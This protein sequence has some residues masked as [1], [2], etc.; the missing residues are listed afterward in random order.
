[1]EIFYR[2]RESRQQM[3]KELNFLQIRSEKGLQHIYYVA[4][5]MGHGDCIYRAVLSNNLWW[6]DIST[7]F[8]CC[9]LR[10]IGRNLHRDVRLEDR[11][12]DEYSPRFEVSFSCLIPTD[13]PEI[14]KPE[15]TRKCLCWNWKEKSYILYICIHIMACEVYEGITVGQGTLDVI[16][17]CLYLSCHDFG[18]ALSGRIEGTAKKQVGPSSTMFGNNLRKEVSSILPKQLSTE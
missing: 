7:L 8:S 9:R 13:L 3:S 6:I 11:D 10:R 17:P 4:D 16:W 2:T 14:Q 5:N 18:C 1:M 15:T 12:T